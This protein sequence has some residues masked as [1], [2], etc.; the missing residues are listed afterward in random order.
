MSE[1]KVFTDEERMALLNRTQDVVNHPE[2]Y[3]KN[4]IECI[5]AI[6][7]SM[8]DKLFI[9]YCKGN[10]IK[11]LWRLG[12]KDSTVQDAKKAQWYMNKLVEVLDG[13]AKTK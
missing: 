7:A 3:T 8:I 2:H 5:D 6:Q 4:G 1:M 11:Y 12:L 10:V 13:Q 9:G